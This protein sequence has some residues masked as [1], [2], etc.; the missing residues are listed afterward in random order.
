MRDAILIGVP[1]EGRETELFDVQ[2]SV[3]PTQLLSHHIHAHWVLDVDQ[4][5]RLAKIV[6]IE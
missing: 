6:T 4:L 3:V 5:C 1:P 2:L